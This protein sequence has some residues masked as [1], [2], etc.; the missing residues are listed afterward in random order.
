LTTSAIARFPFREFF[1]RKRITKA[2]NYKYDSYKR[3]DGE[4]GRSAGKNY[5]INPEIASIL[6]QL[7]WNRT[8]LVWFSELVRRLRPAYRK[9]LF[10]KGDTS[11]ELP[12]NYVA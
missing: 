1:N 9:S 2:T 10:F 11:P 7:I 5:A 3:A 8:Y 12:E 4:G 6:P